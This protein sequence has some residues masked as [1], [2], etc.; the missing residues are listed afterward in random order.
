MDLIVPSEFMPKLVWSLGEFEI[1]VYG[2][3]SIT[4]YV[5]NYICTYTHSI[6][7]IIACIQVFHH[8]EVIQTNVQRHIP[9]KDKSVAL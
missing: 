5:R 2:E 9:E 7:K 4:F 8:Y 3:K 1:F 6:C